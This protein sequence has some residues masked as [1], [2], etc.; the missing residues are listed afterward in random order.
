[1]KT[2]LGILDVIGYGTTVVVVIAFLAGIYRWIAGISPALWRLGKGLADRKIAVFADGDDFN[3]IRDLLID[4]NL[5]KGKNISQITKNEIK[6]AGQYSL[7]LAHWK[8]I[9][10]H[11]DGILSEKKDG[12]ALL[13]Y[14]PQEE[15]FI[16]K[17]DIARIN[18]HRNVI[19]VNFRGRLLNDIMISLITTSYER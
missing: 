2:F 7:F 3:S 1:M 15:G 12:T 16:P 17:E 18:Q 6:K 9:S 8:S 14:A 10:S 5:F 19:V 13:I 11:L 4:S